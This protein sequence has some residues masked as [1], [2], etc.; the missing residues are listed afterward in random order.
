M[1]MDFV[2]EV[3]LAYAA[4]RLPQDCRLDL[5]LVFIS[6]VLVMAAPAFAEI[7]AG[8]LDAVR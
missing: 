3:D 5:Q 7:R 4:E 1:D 2:H 8:G 6:Y